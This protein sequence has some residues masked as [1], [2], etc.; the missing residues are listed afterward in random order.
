[1]FEPALLQELV[2]RELHKEKMTEQVM[3]KPEGKEYRPATPL[4]PKMAML[5]GGL[6]DAASTYGFLKSGKME[7][8]NPMF[9]YFNKAPW[10]VIP[11]AAAVGLGYNTLHNLISKKSP[12]AADTIAGLLGGYQMALGGSNIENTVRPEPTESGYSLAAKDLNLG[13]KV[14]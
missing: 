2:E 1:M 9:K 8:G 13:M 10:S 5:L 14:K 6:A 11:T 3:P 4:S 12:K 7:E